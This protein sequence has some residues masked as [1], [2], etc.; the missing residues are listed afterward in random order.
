MMKIVLAIGQINYDAF[1]ENMLKAVK[2]HPEQLGGVKLPPFS[3]KLLKMIPA[4]K[5]N[6]MLAQAINDNKDKMLAQAE[7]MLAPYTGPVKLNN[8]EIGCEKD[9]RD[10][11]TV[12][13][14]L[15]GYDLHYL[16]D[17]L[18]PKYYS[19]QT[20]PFMLGEDYSG[21]Y[22]L[23]V[24]SDYMKQ[25]EPKQCQLLFAKS[26]SANRP[27]LIYLLENGARSRDIELTV[28]TIRFMVK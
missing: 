6:E 21:S 28:N 23:S 9:G 3:G 1:L 12:T 15:S 4:H 19:E 24:V 17:H 20:A 25:Q 14:E 13:L 11:M 26:L 8:L 16:I 10:K 5:K 18:L 7:T 22:E 2:D 27:Y